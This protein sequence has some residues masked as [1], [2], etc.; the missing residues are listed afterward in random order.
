MKILIV[1]AGIAGLAAARAFEMHGYHPEIVERH[2]ECSTAGQSIFLLGNAMRALGT[3]GLQER[4]KEISSPIQTQTIFSSSG[5]LLNRV[6]TASVW[7]KCGPCVA[8][9][10]NQ[11]IEVMR[12]SLTST[13]ITFGTTVKRTVVRMDKRHVYLPDGQVSDYD[14]VIGAD[15]A[16]SSLRAATFAQSAPRLIGHSAWRLAVDNSSKLDGWTAMLGTGRTLLAIPLPNSKLYIY[17]DCPTGEFGD[18]S[19]SV[20]K[21]LFSEFAPPLGHIVSGINPD[22]EVHRAEIE[23][24]AYRDYVADRLVLIG[25]AAHASSPSMAQGAGMAIEDAIVLTDCLSRN[26]PIDLA[27]SQFSELRRQRVGWVQK[28][29][30]ARDKLRGAPDVVRNLLLRTLGTKLYHRSYDILVEPW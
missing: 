24:V 2:T 14:L 12:E 26:Q 13:R 22:A 19:I 27:L 20:M 28:Q 3:L 8:V 21:R 9:L 4:V 1:G 11:L 17:A 18:G 16:R 25:D 7:E 5:K 10:R 29:C 6:P 30:H 15:G 23:E